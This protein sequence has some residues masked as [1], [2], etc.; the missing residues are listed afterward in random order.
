MGCTG[1][2][3][4]WRRRTSRR[5]CRPTK[6]G[7]T[8]PS[9]PRDCPWRSG[10]LWCAR[11]GVGSARRSCI[12]APS[13]GSRLRTSGCFYPRGRGRRCAPAPARRIP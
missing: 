11:C 6:Q 5:S 9:P 3:G 12:C 8:G 1:S 2:G 7:W 10:R 13:R 4:S